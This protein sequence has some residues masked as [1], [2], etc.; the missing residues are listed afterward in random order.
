VSQRT[1]LVSNGTGYGVAWQDDRHGNWEVYFARLYSDGT[2]IGTEARLTNGTANADWPELAWNGFE[3]GISWRDLRGG[4][5]NLYYATLD[6]SGNK[7]GSDTQLTS[8]ST[9]ACA[10]RMAW[11]GDAY[12]MAWHDNRHG[13]AEIYFSRV[14]CCGDADADGYEAC[15]G[16]C[17]DRNPDRN[18]GQAELCDG[19]DN[20]CDGLLPV[21]EMDLDSDGAL[22]CGDD[23]D[24]SDALIYGGAPEINDGRDNQCPGSANYGVT[25]E[26]S[27][28]A[29]FLGSDKETYSWVP[30]PGAMQ[31][32]V[33]RS[34]APD[35]S[36]GCTITTTDQSK[37]VDGEDPAAAAVFYYLVRPIAPHVGSWGL[38]GWGAERTLTCP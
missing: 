5:N 36:S 33:A 28:E 19:L 26:L 29:G 38:T 35:F 20:D 11:S 37:W 8:T 3:Y 18:P 13:N 2:M 14:G 17:D 24:D 30:Q 31:Y 21:D 16:D 4:G 22:A 27:G 1:A 9:D 15:A 10:M 25:D 34:T 32:E 12:G 6:P 23:C 7:V